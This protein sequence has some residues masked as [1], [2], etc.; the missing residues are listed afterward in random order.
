[1]ASHTLIDYDGLISA[2]R[3]LLLI[4]NGTIDRKSGRYRESGDYLGDAYGRATKESYRAFVNAF[5]KYL[6]ARKIEEIVKQHAEAQQA[7]IESIGL[8][9]GKFIVK[10]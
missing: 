7:R 9:N 8:P 10:E 1:M 4:A 6:P 5:R 2:T 3:D